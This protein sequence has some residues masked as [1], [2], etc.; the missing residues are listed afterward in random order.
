MIAHDIIMMDDDII[1]IIIIALHEIII[2]N[3]CKFKFKVTTF[4]IMKYD[5]TLYYHH[6][7]LNYLQHCTYFYQPTNGT[8]I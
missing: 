4:E 5:R 2:T 7:S 6:Y 1:V 3:G 8:T